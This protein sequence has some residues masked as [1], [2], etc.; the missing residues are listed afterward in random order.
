MKKP[1]IYY[2]AILIFGWLLLG[3]TPVYGKSPVTF[4]REI[5]IIKTKNGKHSFNAEIAETKE[6]LETGLMYRTSLADDAAMF[7]IFKDNSK[8]N[9]WMKDTM[10]SLDM[11]FIDKQG[12][13]V[14]I[15][16]NTKTDSLNIITA[17]D[18]PVKAVLELKGGVSESRNINI[19]DEVIYKGIMK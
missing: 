15:A 3:L 11:L 5:I 9:M 13:I 18:K 16:K 12:K 14:Y 4:E 6:Q 10:I 17:G 19:G 7:F 2:P 1:Y 8:I